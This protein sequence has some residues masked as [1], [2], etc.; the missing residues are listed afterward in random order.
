MA[1]PAPR[2]APTPDFFPSGVIQILE[3]KEN[4][5]K[6]RDLARLLGVSRQHVYRMAAGEGLP[7]FRMGRAVRFDPKQVA[8]W[9]VKKMPHTE[10]SSSLRK[11][12]V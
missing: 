8:G 9:L 6:A 12:A 11:I 3:A 7:F 2:F 1:T 5:L 4:A 10:A